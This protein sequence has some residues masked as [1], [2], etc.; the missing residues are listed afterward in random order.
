[1]END[2]SGTKIEV[3][4]GPLSSLKRVEHLRGSKREI[5]QLGTSYNNI[6]HGVELLRFKILQPT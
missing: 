3:L 2:R 1:M 4:Q 6:I 5:V